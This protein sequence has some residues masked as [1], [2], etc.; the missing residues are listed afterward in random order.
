MLLLLVFQVQ[1]CCSKIFCHGSKY[2]RGQGR[3]RNDLTK[4]ARIARNCDVVPYR[5][6]FLPG[7]K[8]RL[9]AAHKDVIVG[10]FQPVHHNQA[11]RP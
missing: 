3:N 2:I 10:I 8:F 5:V 4:R 6:V 11:C 9:A 7:R 1:V